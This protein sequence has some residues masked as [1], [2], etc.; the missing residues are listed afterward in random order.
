ML[1]DKSNLNSDYFEN[2]LNLLQNFIDINESL[3]GKHPL[4][5]GMQKWENMRLISLDLTANQ[6]THIPKDICIIAENLIE[7]DLSN[8][9]ICPP[10]PECIESIDKQ[11]MSLC[12]NYN[13]PEGYDNIEGRC[14][15]QMHLQIL[16]DI[17]DSNA[18]L[19]GLKPLEIAKDIGLQKWESGH[20]NRLILSGNQLTDI[21][22][23]ICDVASQLAAF[24]ISNNS[25]CPPYP[26][27]IENIG[28]QN[29][30]DCVQ[31][32]SCPEG[33][34]TFDERCYFNKDLQVL[35]DFTKL[36]PAIEDYQPL[37]LG[38]QIWKSNRLQLLNLDGLGISLVPE[39][40]QNLEHLE[41][42]N[43]NNNKL[44]TLPETLCKIYPNLIWIDLT[45]NYLCQPYINCFDYIGQQNTENCQ[46]DY[47]T[48]GYQEYDEECYYQKDLAVLQDF[49]D[50]NV[51]L[52]GR[53]PL[54]IGVQ[55]WKN[56]R[57]DFLYLGVNELTV[58]PESICGIYTNIS[59]INIS[60]NKI[61]PPYP[62]CITEIVNKQDTSNC[63]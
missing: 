6:L 26:A 40:I 7:L 28:Y 51:S 57:L 32:I 17:I 62:A 14:Y 31:L 30:H 22:E 25:I 52:S 58:I 34:I 61:C 37:M 3:E 44:N 60:R 41:Y 47:C 23:S 27:C 42:L 29:T 45:N 15:Y 49:I 8:N 35:I 53:K 12:S 24:D 50:E 43:L 20:L 39:S 1:T 13:C 59:D 33:Y 38:Y 11:E 56:M 36:N 48:V 5:I 46:K 4:E 16:Q 19:Q 21:P 63:P 10:Y 9:S 55:K 2:D 18:S 54:D